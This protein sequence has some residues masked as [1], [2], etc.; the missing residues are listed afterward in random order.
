MSIKTQSRVWDYSNLEG[1]NLNA[2]LSLADWADDDGISWYDNERLAQRIRR[3]PRQITRIMD[4]LREAGEIYA[5]PQFGR[6]KKNLK[7]VCIGLPLETIQDVLARRFKLSA[8]EANAAARDILERQAIAAQPA[9]KPVTD[10]TFLDEKP[11]MH[12]GFCDEEKGVMDDG[13][14][15]GDENK[16]VADDAFL[17]EKPVMD[18]GLKPIKPVIAMTGD[19][20]IRVVVAD[21]KVKQT[22]T[23]SFAAREQ[24]ADTLAWMGFSG[25]A[26]DEPLTPVTALAWAFHVQINRERW[27][28]QGKDPVGITVALWRKENSRPA[29]DCQ[30]L[31][32]AWLNMRQDERRALL[33]A[34]ADPFFTG[35]SPL[36]ECLQPFNVPKE[37]ARKLYLSTGGRL[38]PPSLMPPDL[39]EPDYLDEPE[40]VRLVTPASRPVAAER[41]S[42]DESRVWKAALGEL[43]LQMTR[44][45]FNTWLK[46][47]QLHLNGGNTAVVMVRNEQAAEWINAR[48]RDTI[49]RTLR[50]VAERPDLEVEARVGE[51]V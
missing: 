47:S 20:S 28:K 12:D 46:G 8:L 31:A 10:D 6:G 33:D 16:P 35:R 18:D 45:T 22:T 50:G 43:E 51:L 44:A 34:V 41:M 36:P 11:V 42:A 48:L 4:K 26:E 23:A 21:T 29:A 49:A 19:P 17:G 13:F 1:T 5:P 37:F 25:T 2:M 40:P 15:V 7:F 3:K 39:P 27:E 14:S 32:A 30:A 24:I 9:T 38:A